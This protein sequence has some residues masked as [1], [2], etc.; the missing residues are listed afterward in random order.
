MYGEHDGG[1]NTRA[2]ADNIRL[3]AAYLREGKT[4]IAK[5]KILIAQKEAPN[6]APV[7]D[8]LALF[9]ASTGEPKKAEKY[10]QE[11]IR[12]NSH[13][14]SLQNN[15]GTFLCG[16][17]K[18]RRAISRF[19]NAVA[20]PKYVSTAAAYENAGICA[21]KIP[22]NALAFKYFKKA[23]SISSLRPTSLYELSNLNYQRGDYQRANELLSRYQSVAPRSPASLW[24]SI[25]IAR[26]LKKDDLAA[27]QALLLKA[28]YPNTA[29]TKALLASEKTG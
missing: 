3:S 12:L 21:M 28:K 14:G 6:W 18:Y 8:G 11:A 24:L 9:Y 26:K 22:D 15:Y 2:A 25:R 17:G 5:E 10:Y 13:A 23:L 27:S 1:Q 29:Q 7:F 4:Q 20:D 16:Q 19:M